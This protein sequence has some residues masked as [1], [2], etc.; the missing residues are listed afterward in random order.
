MAWALNAGTATKVV[1]KATPGNVFAVYVTNVNAAVRW[2]QFH[3]K[4][5][6]PAGAETA[7]VYFPIPAG[8]A[9][10]PGVL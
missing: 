1:V 8:S 3:N 6:D 7:Q 9:T 5:T 10:V 4:A 2:F